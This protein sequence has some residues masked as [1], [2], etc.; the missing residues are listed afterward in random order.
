MVALTRILFDGVFQFLF[1]VL[2]ATI[3]W[4]TFTYYLFFMKIK[5]DQK[6]N[7]SPVLNST[8]VISEKKGT[9]FKVRGVMIFSL[10]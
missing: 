3:S 10:G 7:K 1:G 5:R 8:L 6:I 9:E 4:Q 2:L